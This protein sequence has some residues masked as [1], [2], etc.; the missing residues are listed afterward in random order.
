MTQLEFWAVALI[1]CGVVLA[2]VAGML[3]D[4]A[5]TNMADRWWGEYPDYDPPRNPRSKTPP[6]G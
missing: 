5:L 1:L 2:Y 6:L 3:A 4:D